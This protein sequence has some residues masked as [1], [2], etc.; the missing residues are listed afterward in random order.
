VADLKRRA[1][2]RIVTW[3]AESDLSRDLSLV[4]SG[5]ASSRLLIPE[6]ADCEEKKSSQESFYFVKEGKAGR[7][8]RWVDEHMRNV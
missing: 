8:A 7:T 4:M 3:K 5:E 1:W 6:P 2:D